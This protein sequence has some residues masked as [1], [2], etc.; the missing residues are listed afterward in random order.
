MKALTNLIVILTFT[1]QINC[2]IECKD[3]INLYI[4]RRTLGVD[5]KIEEENILKHCNLFDL[6]NAFKRVESCE[7][8]VIKNIDC[9]EEYQAIQVATDNHFIDHLPLEYD[10]LYNCKKKIEYVRKM[11]ESSLNNRFEYDPQNW[12]E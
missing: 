2:N 1:S 6:N 8:P 5:V 4:Q 9:K 11:L 3:D 12:E 7:C 10:K